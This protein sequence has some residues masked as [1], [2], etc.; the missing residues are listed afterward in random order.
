M[1]E[2]VVLVKFFHQMRWVLAEREPLQDETGL[3]CKNGTVGSGSP[4]N[5][6]QKKLKPVF[7]PVLAFWGGVVL[8][9]VRH[10][11]QIL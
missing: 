9:K 3:P 11:S 5:F 6:K 8:K 4:R 7:T 2:K 10:P 1:S